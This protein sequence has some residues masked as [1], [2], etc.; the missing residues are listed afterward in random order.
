LS[1][2]DVDTDQALMRRV[3]AGDRRAYDLLFAR[4]SEPI[5]GYLLRRTL[6]RARAEEAHQ[7]T[8]LRV[9]KHADRFDAS[10]PFKPWLYRIATHA[11][12]DTFD[13]RGEHLELKVE[14]AAEGDPTELRDTLVSALAGLDP[15]DRR[16]LLLTVEGF[17]CVEISELMSEGERP[18]SHGA[19]RNRLWR[20]RD[21]IR[22]KLGGRP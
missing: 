1:R 18:L 21:Q 15:A 22:S 6:S 17:D 7:E 5:F 13:G 19:V 16:I 4:W 11:G 10:R 12:I 2:P 8:W 20:A 14:P 9:Y 3:A